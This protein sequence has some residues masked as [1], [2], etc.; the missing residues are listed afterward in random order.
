MDD[1]EK[2][3]KRIKD[4]ITVG[5]KAL[6][7]IKKQQ[8][9]K[10]TLTVSAGDSISTTGPTGLYEYCPKCE[11]RKEVGY[12]GGNRR[13]FYAEEEKK[14]EKLIKIAMKAGFTSDDINLLIKR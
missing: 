12:I 6:A 11:W 8:A 1:F 9:C 3:I 10:H 7:R 2:R 13:V 5:K 4:E 14:R